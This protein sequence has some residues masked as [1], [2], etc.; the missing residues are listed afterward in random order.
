MGYTV[1]LDE[2]SVAPEAGWSPTKDAHLIAGHTYVIWTFDNHFAKVRI[3][4]I[5]QDAVTLD[6]AYQ[7]ATGNPELL[8]PD[9][10]KLSKSGKRSRH[11]KR[12]H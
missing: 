4:E 7:T 5:S 12:V 6:W 11:T 3:R 10:T 2:I 9:E 8:R 1:N